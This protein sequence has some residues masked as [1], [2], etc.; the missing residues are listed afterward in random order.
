MCS[1]SYVVLYME[2]SQILCAFEC[3]YKVQL[4]WTLYVLMAIFS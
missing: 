3:K 4:K 1:D 2:I